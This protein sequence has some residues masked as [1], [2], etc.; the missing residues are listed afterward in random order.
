MLH[1][2]LIDDMWDPNNWDLTP[3]DRYIYG[4]DMARS[5]A[6][7]DE[8]DY[9][10][11]S[12]HLWC[13]IIMRSRRNPSKFKIYMRRAVGENAHGKRLRTY[14]LYLHREIL[15]LSDPNPPTPR[16]IIADHR[17][18]ETMNCRR[19]NLRWATHSM[20]SINRFGSHPHDLVDG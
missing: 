9:P 14:T 4:D 17:D 18:G 1:V 6:V 2:P 3:S 19:S 16:H 10:W 12:K 8:V 20:N 7:I 15:K 11:V 5:W 13:P